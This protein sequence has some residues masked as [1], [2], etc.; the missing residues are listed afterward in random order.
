MGQAVITLPPPGAPVAVPASAN[1][2]SL[3]QA[4]I[5][6]GSA[7]NQALRGNL[8]ATLQLTLAVGD[9]TST[10]SDSRIG[11]YSHIQFTPLTAHAAQIFASGMWVQLGDRSATIHHASTGTFSDCTFNACILGG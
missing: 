8:A 6:L 10:F 11:P 1:L 5:R 2:P 3:Q 4:A 9:T 7:V